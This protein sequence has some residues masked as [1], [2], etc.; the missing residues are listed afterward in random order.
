[1]EK[2]QELFIH[3]DGKKERLHRVRELIAMLNPC[4]F[5]HLSSYID[6][7]D[8]QTLELPDRVAYREL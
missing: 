4:S 5:S 6:E 7:I 1:M 8:N 3:F 2:Q